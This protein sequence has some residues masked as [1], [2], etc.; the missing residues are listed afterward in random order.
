[1]TRVLVVGDRFIPARWRTLDNVTTTTHF[2]GDTE[3]TN[4]TSA[5]LVAAVVTEFSET[6]TV[7]GAV[8]AAE[9]GWT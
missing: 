7:P 2:G 3:E 1:M 9:L 5:A 6:G 8:N 4:R